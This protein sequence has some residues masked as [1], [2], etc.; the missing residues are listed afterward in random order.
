MVR[1]CFWLLDIAY[2]HPVNGHKA[3]KTPPV[4]V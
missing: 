3:R 4:L 1:L 2:A